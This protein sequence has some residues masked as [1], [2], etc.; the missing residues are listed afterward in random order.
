[1]FY[2][3]KG[4]VLHISK[5]FLVLDCGGVG[6]KIMTSMN[7]LGKIGRTEQEVMLYT[8]LYVKEDALDLFGFYDE[9]ELN[10]F[11]LLI[12]VSGVG[13]KAALS[14]LS[15]LSPEKFALSVAAEDSKAIKQAQGI[16]PK[17][18]Q[19]IVL[20]LKDKLK[21]SDVAQGF[22]AGIVPLA[23]GGNASEAVS[24]LLVLGYSAG[25]AAGAIAPLPPETP[26][27]DMIKSAL[28]T[29][30]SRN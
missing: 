25:E 12:S 17:I 14:V 18:A 1:M 8:H 13:P 3:I 2:S 26:V 10:C 22:T 30:V 11:R 16:G 6:F 27:A 29:L 4:Q 21:T 9:G 24:A 15:V 23:Y 20:E 7:T 19:R 5:N 28:K